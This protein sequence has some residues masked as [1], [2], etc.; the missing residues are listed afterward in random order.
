MTHE[1]MMTVQYRQRK[2]DIVVSSEWTVQ[3]LIEEIEILF[4][5]SFRGMTIYSKNRECLL[6]YDDWTLQ[7]YQL[8]QGEWLVIM[9]DTDNECD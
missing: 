8:S 2:E 7:D 4:Q 1:L 5:K 9:E 3:R 6:E